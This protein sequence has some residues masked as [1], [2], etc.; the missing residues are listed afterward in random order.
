MPW[1]E[2]LFDHRYVAFYEELLDASVASRDVDFL[3]RAMALAEGC[4]ILDL[5]CGFGRHSIEL[6]AREYRV[7]GVDLSSSMLDMARASA[8]ER[9]VTVELV[10]RDM[11]A[12]S[13]LGPFDICICIYTVLGYFD[14]DENESVLRGVHDVL[15]PGGRL[16]IDLT[17]PLRMFKA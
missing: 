15:A 6:A 3:D 7:T 1:Y 13:G 5:G 10:Q 16:A 14:D 17:N 8:K 2:S 4:R 12:L 9:G 11:R